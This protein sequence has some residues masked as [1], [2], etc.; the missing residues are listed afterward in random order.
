MKYRHQ[1]QHREEGIKYYIFSHTEI[2]EREY[3]IDI[4]N[5]LHKP[6]LLIVK[7]K[8]LWKPWDLIDY[9]VDELLNKNK[10][11]LDDKDEIWVVF[12]V[13]NFFNNNEKYLFGQAIKKAKDNDIKIAM[14][15][16][17]F[18]LWYI[19]HFEYRNIELHRDKM[20]EII[21]KHFIKNNLGSFSKNEKVFHKL[22][23]KLSTAIDNSKK[24]LKDKYN[25]EK[26]E[27]INWESILSEK[28]NPSTTLHF[29]IEDILKNDK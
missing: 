5:S 27:D 29:L 8:V 21:N 20:E 6:H 18:E 13:D 2:C 12:D 4:K 17:C 23:N 26:Y 25:I 14:S 15:N 1:R 24:L 7:N 3:F 16:Q 28:G 19:L 10:I 9:I 11:E 22:E